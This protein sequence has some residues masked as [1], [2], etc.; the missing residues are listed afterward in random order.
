MTSNRDII[1]AR[2]GEGSAEDNRAVSSRTAALEFHY[3]QKH[4]DE[5]VTKDRRV[6]EVGCATGY[7]GLHYADRCR[8]YVGIDIFPPH[9]ETFE[10][11][12]RENG[13]KN[14][15][16]QVGDGTNLE[17]TPD[18]AFDVVLCLGPMYHLPPEERELVFAECNRVCAPDGVVAFAYINK[19]GVYAGACVQDDWRDIYPNAYATECVLEKG[20]SD[21]RP[22]LF[23]LTMPEEIEE[24]ATRHG[25]V[26]I[27][28]LGTNFMFTMKVVNDMDDERFALMRPI[29]DQM[30]S[31]ESCTG[32]SDHALLVCRKTA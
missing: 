23:Y 3:T 11:K 26:K 7:Y 13:L 30:T 17:N 15:T 32:M 28:N 24:V 5:F 12:I 1:F 10:R 25:L 18:A 2:Y 19:V 14:V 31:Y 27:K 6:L 9:I 16:C 29:Y 22:G 21:N 20:T 8:E 4:L